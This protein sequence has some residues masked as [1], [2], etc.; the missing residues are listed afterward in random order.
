M[1]RR[2]TSTKTSGIC[3]VCGDSC[4][5]RQGQRKA[6]HT[7]AS[8]YGDL[9]EGIPPAR[10]RELRDEWIDRN[11]EGN[12]IRELLGSR[13]TLTV[14]APGQT[15]AVPRGR[16]R[17]QVGGIR[18]LQGPKLRETKGVFDFSGQTFTFIEDDGIIW[19][20]DTNTA[21]DEKRLR[22]H[23]TFKEVA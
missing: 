15:V 12:P 17:S 22:S 2:W 16:S 13:A 18:T 7:E 8:H 23:L 5:P 20:I 19:E 21:M 10:R 11:L 1:K 3:R 4:H 9:M 14:Y 6:E